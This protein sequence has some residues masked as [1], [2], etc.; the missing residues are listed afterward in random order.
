MWPPG[1]KTSTRSALFTETD[2]RHWC[3]PDERQRCPRPGLHAIAHA[4]LSDVSD[5]L[6]QPTLVIGSDGDTIT[7][8]D[9]VE[10]LA[11]T[12]PN[13]S[14]CIISGA[15]HLPCVDAPDANAELMFDFLR[16][17]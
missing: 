11:A 1:G 5:K 3:Y 4:D 12:I 2:G 14:L 13:S 7:P 15:S 9:V 16:A 17:S 10:R 6:N 8:P